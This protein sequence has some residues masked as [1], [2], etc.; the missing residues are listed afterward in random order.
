M[1]DGRQRHV[2]EGT[3]QGRPAVI[4]GAV[5]GYATG[6]R[7][8]P[9]THFEA[10][11]GGFLLRLPLISTLAAACPLMANPVLSLSALADV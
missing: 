10:I 6:A 5:G 2:C 1:A 7:C 11:G 3:A 8:G 9:G 4:V